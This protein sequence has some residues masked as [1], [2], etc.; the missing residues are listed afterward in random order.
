MLKDDRAR[1]VLWNFHRQWLGLDRVLGDEHL[2]R[3][4]AVDPAWS[5]ASQLA[6][7]R[8][9]QLFVENVLMESGSLK[10]L[11]T[12]RRA[13]VNGEMARVYGVTPP[14]DP[15]VFAP[16]LLPNDERAGI[17][18]RAAFLAGYSHRGA[19]SPPIR[20]NGIQLRLLCQFLRS[21]PPGV[22]LSMPT[23]APGQGPQTNRMLFEARTRPTFC[24]G[25]HTG[26]NGFGFG[27]EHYDAAGHYQA[28]E[29]GLP[30]DARGALL[31][32]DVDRPFDG[33]LD[34]SAALADSKVVDRC[35]TQQWIR[36]ALGR[37]PTA[38]EEPVLDALATQLHASGGD[39]RALL[40]A[41][42]TA[43]TFRL[44]RVGP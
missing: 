38:D 15:G 20:G 16:T 8:E 39:L 10:E 24:M 9:S 36:Y 21:P 19:T 17:L 44:R 14:A 25:C 11:L 37:A 40:V 22:D 41:I 18:T 35:A 33:A 30:I 23:A 29:V 42:V 4:P 2:V 43:P 7:L 12:S 3:T 26:L 28:S 6:A 13:W 27:L 1:R 31:G 32:T 5:S 34:L